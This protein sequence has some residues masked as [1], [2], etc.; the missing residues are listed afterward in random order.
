MILSFHLRAFRYLRRFTLPSVTFLLMLILG[1]VSV[2]SQARQEVAYDFSPSQITGMYQRTLED[3]SVQ[4]AD[5]STSRVEL[6]G[7]VGEYAYRRYYPFEVVGRVSFDLGQ[8]LGQHLMSLTAGAGYTRQVY[9]RYYPFGQLT[10]GIA[11]TSSTTLQYL[12]NSGS[13]GFA[14]NFAGGLDIDVTRRFGV[15]A[16]EFQNQ[17]L[18]FGVNHLGSVYW[19]FGTGAYYRFGK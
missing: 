17:Y 2:H 11:H 19:S 4:N 14:L 9:R 8:P 6:N 3:Y 18:P 5:K 7:G 16:I 13:T 12:R 10:A 15:R 1:V